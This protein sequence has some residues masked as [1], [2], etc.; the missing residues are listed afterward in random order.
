MVLSESDASRDY[1]RLKHNLANDTDIDLSFGT[2]STGI[3]DFPKTTSVQPDIQEKSIFNSNVEGDLFIE[4]YFSVIDSFSSDSTSVKI[5]LDFSEEVEHLMIYDSL[6]SKFISII[7]SNLFEFINEEKVVFENKI[8]FQEDWEIPNYKKLILKISFKDFP[9]NQKMEI[10]KKISD[11]I[12]KQIKS[13]ISDNTG[14]AIIKLKEFEKKFFIK[15][16][17]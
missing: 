3:I 12:H 17:F 13:Y 7:E 5:P 4:S 2:N 15:L 8:D 1:S 14:E 16:D 10:W 9:F 11:F 6:F